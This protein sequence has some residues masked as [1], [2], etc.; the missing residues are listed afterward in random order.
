MTVADAANIRTTE[1][2]IGVSRYIEYHFPYLKMAS[3]FLKVRSPADIAWREG[4]RALLSE[5]R[6]IREEMQESEIR[7]RALDKS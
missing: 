2:A 1:M 6:A 4:V 7:A 3:L 5:Y